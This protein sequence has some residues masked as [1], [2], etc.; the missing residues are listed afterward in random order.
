MRALSATFTI[1]VGLIVLCAMPRMSSAYTSCSNTY[2][3]GVTLR[4]HC[5]S[6]S[7]SSA[8]LNETYDCFCDS[9]NLFRVQE[10]P[11]QKGAATPF[12]SGLTCYCD[13]ANSVASA[14]GTACESDANSCTADTCGSFV[15]NNV[16]YPSGVCTHV[17]VAGGTV[18]TDDGNGCTSD[19]CD[20]MANCT[21]PPQVG[22]ACPDDGNAC[23][24]D[25]C[26][27][28]G[29]CTHPA[30]TGAACTSDGNI[31]TTDACSSSGACGHVNGTGGSVCNNQCIPSGTCCATPNSCSGGRTCST[32]GGNCGCPTNTY[33]CGGA[34]I[35]NGTCCNA[36]NNCSG[37]KACSGNGGSCA[38]PA[39]TSDCGGTCIAAGTCCPSASN[40]TG[41]KTCS[42]VG[43]SCNCPAGTSDCGGTCIA[44]GTCCASP[45]SCAGGQVCSGAGGS[46]SCPGGTYLCNGACVTNGTCCT[47]QAATC[48]GG[49][50]CNIDGGTC[51]CPAGKTYCDLSNSCIPSSNCCRDSNCTVP[52]SCKTATGATC[53]A[54][55]CVYPND[56]GASCNADST[57]C[58][59]NDK[60][61]GGTCVADTANKVKCVQK[62]CHT[63]PLCN[64]GTGNCD[65][66]NVGNGTACGGNGCSSMVGACT[67]GTCSVTPKDC[68][69]LNT[70]CKVGVCDPTQMVGAP[71]ATSNTM[72]GTSCTLADKCVLTTACSGGDCVG[73]K[74]VCDAP[75]PCHATTCNS[76][77]GE[78]DD[79]FLPAGTACFQNGACRQNAACDANGNC[80]GDSVP[81]GT[82]CSKGGCQ[83]AAACVSSSCI[84]LNRADLGGDPNTPITPTDAPDMSAATGGGEK[85]GCSFGGSHTSNDAAALAF[86]LA[87]LAFVLRRKRVRAR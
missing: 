15:S 39:G 30:T 68:T 27:A 65:D 74:K 51:V 1:F 79:S 83:G 6:L 12:L 37:A 71:C 26:D 56:D 76:T 84:C 44:A 11:R 24:S 57:K 18:C 81:D 59:P 35:A 40:C 2:S 45:N 64:P 9:A 48:S 49:K 31:C 69:A 14:P 60:C 62:D 23:T 50:V 29:T 77:T 4:Q 38:C 5:Q 54:G 55:T 73:T 28:G 42:A 3:S 63:P 86:V 32:D 47:S 13:V 66:A 67:S 33:D 10:P 19:N 72:N 22:A 17:A 82:P 53:N 58:T 34:C 61:L 78:C 87:A 46:C 8:C 75:A 41:G 7:T 21:H 16:T 85:K 36:P 80:V 70:Q 25:V 43:G 20:A 52:P